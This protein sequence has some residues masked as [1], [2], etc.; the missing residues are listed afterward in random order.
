MKKLYWG[1]VALIFLLTPAANA[2]FGI[3]GGLTFNQLSDAKVNNVTESF[4]SAQGK[5]LGIFYGMG[6]NVGL[7][8][9]LRYSDA[10][11]LYKGLSSGNTEGFKASFVEM[12]VD[13]RLR[14]NTPLLKPYLVAGPLLRVAAGSDNDEFKDAIKSLNVAASIGGGVELRLGGLSLYP[15]INYTVGVSSFLKTGATVGGISINA[16]DDSQ[17]NQFVIKLGIGFH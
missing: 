15:E 12:P 10:E 5:H 4:E 14:V 8:L 9:G 16:A 7:R 3:E 2:Q 17:L 6:R 11:G 13:L 1:F